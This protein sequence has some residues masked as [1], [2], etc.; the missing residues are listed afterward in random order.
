MRVLDVNTATLRDLNLLRGIG[1]VTARRIIA[2]RPYDEPDDLVS[3]GVLRA[4]SYDQN[5]EFLSV[6]RAW[7]G[8]T[9]AS[10][11]T[12]APGLRA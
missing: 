5:A 1:E 6:D 2:H 11:L 10:R 9:R 12:R 4:R 7:R 3:R 8:R